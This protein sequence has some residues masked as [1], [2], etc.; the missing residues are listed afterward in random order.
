MI[1]EIEV[2]A[3]RENFKALRYETRIADEKKQVE[4]MLMSKLGK[5]KY[6]PAQLVQ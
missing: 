3:R 1:S 4:D 6:S 5:W 2:R